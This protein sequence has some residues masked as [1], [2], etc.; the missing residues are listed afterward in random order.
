MLSVSPQT[1]RQRK[2][3][4]KRGCLR[5][6]PD[7]MGG[8]VGFCHLLPPLHSPL[9]T[10]TALLQFHP[11]ALPFMVPSW[12]LT[13]TVSDFYVGLCIQDISMTIINNMRDK[14]GHDP[15]WKM[16][17]GQILAEALGNILKRSSRANVNEE[18]VCWDTPYAN[19]N[20]SIL[21]TFG[22]LPEGLAGS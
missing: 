15:G 3:S 9:P 21:P 17:E 22:T 1:W 6:C 4:L 7:W 20:L 18:S 8:P 12:V 11:P 16:T 5:G 10:V 19:P 2:T 13:S 14:I